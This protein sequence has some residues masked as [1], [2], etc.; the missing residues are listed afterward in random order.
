MPNPGNLN[1]QVFIAQVYWNVGILEY[2]NIGF[3]IGIG[4]FFN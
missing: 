3:K 1:Q 2:W 4:L